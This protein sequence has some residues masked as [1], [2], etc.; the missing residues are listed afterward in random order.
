MTMARYAALHEKLDSFSRRLDARARE[1]RERG[2]F[3]DVHETFVKPILERRDQFR[4]KLDSAI[5]NGT[6]WDL[7]K[8]EFTRDI[9]SLI[10]E[11]ARMEE[12]LDAE[13]MKKAAR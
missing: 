4:K 9:E 3:A 12:R 11:F 7:I 8:V 1:L 6:D 13:T 2:E 10:S 5:R